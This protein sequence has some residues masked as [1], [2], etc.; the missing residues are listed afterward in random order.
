MISS[1]G[2]T[3]VLGLP[4]VLWIG[5]VGMLCFLSAATIQFCNLYTKIRIPVKWHARLAIS[6]LIIML[7][8]AALA[9]AI[10]L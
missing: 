5:L 6:G 4:A 8:H 10:Y 1:L 7:I 9:I 3:P 2:Y